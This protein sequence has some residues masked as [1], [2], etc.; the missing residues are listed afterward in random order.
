M[1]DDIII[2]NLNVL[3]DLNIDDILNNIDNKLIIDKE[4]ENSFQE[5]NSPNLE[6]IILNTL[7]LSIHKKTNKL[8][9]KDDLL[10]LLNKCIDNIYENKYLHNILKSEDNESR[11]NYFYTSLD[12]I[13]NIYKDL[14]N[15]YQRNKCNRF[16]YNLNDMFNIFLKNSILFCKKIHEKNIY[17]NAMNEL[18]SDDVNDDNEDDNEDDNVDVDA[19]NG[20]NSINENNSDD[21]D[22][23]V[24]IKFEVKKDL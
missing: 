20:D 5:F 24:D 22:Y 19:N 11:F 16:I 6:L 18:L 3:F 14:R 17:I 15:K 8:S 21:S 1:G 23:E 2:N 7:C 4:E 9:E 13:N 12:I 10:N